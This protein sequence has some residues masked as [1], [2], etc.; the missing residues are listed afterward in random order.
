MIFLV[1]ISFLL[2]SRPT[3]GFQ[4]GI[5][6][7]PKGDFEFGSEFLD[8]RHDA[9]GN[10]RNAFGVETVHHRLPNVQLVLNRK[11]DEI[12]VNLKPKGKER[13]GKERTRGGGRRFLS[14]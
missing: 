10:V 11:V 3:N 9:V 2:L 14:G 7:Y 13:R 6:G 4:P 1:E 5:L 12:R 8:F